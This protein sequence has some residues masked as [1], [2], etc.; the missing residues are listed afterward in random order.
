MA[1]IWWGLWQKLID[2]NDKIRV[3]KRVLHSVKKNLVL[4]IL[5]WKTNLLFKN[6]DPWRLGRG[7]AKKGWRNLWDS[8]MLYGGNTHIRVI[9]SSLTCINLVIYKS[10]FWFWQFLQLVEV[11][12]LHAKFLCTPCI[13]HFVKLFLFLTLKHRPSFDKQ[14]IR[15]CKAYL[16][17]CLGG[18]N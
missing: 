3:E 6:C 15:I 1:S 10:T 7:G 17:L 16:W 11:V 9:D 18:S 2:D 5:L 12:R 4:R 8:L 13:W 14:I